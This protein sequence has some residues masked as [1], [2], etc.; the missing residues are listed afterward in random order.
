MAREKGSGKLGPTRSLRL[1]H[2]I[3]R[4]FVERLELKPEL[5]PSDVLLQLIYGGLRLRDGYMAIHR[6]ALER[7]AAAADYECY[8]LYRACLTDTF[9]TG[10]VEHLEKWMA[11]D[12][13]TPP[14]PEE[15]RR[16]GT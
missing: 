12:G 6:R 10:Y 1:P 5:S 15:V 7:F 2:A 3:D 16:Y 14:A 11:A 4:W 8:G 9:S 13:I